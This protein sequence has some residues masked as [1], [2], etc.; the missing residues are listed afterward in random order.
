MTQPTE[1]VI[2][3]SQR[4]DF[5]AD[6]W[7]RAP[8]NR[9]TFQHIGEILPTTPVR[10]N[11]DRISP[12]PTSLQKI[13]TIAFRDAGKPTSV[14]EWLDTSFTDGFIVLSKNEIV[15][16]RYFN[17]MDQATLHL[18]QSVSK[19]V[20]GTA[21]GILVSRGLIDPQ[22]SL[23]DVVPELADTAFRHATLRH[24]LDMTSGVRFDENYIDPYSDA[25]RIDV[26]SGW[27]QPTLPG[28]WPAS[29]LE[30]ILALKTL[31][32][33]HGEKFEYRSIETDIITL[34]M[35]KVTGK[36]LADI[37]S[38]EIWQPIGAEAIASFTIDRTG[39]ALGDGGFNA[40]LRD[41]ARFGL[42]WANHGM[43]SG[44]RLISENWIEE[45]RTGDATLFHQP[46]TDILPMGAYRNQFWLKQAKGQVLLCRGVFGQLIYIDLEK[47]FVAVKLSSWPD[48]TDP[49]RMKTAISAI[50]HVAANF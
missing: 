18:A 50:D 20:T 35:E 27:K 19:S 43:A 36:R 44:K 45:T 22:R 49:A 10:N 28:Q 48:F 9:W 21:C 32:R 40:C 15:Y 11:P 33:S 3:G 42:L 17:G 5:P 23:M 8:W 7:D 41:F 26:A 29:M 4:P 24:V 38:D 34:V 25:G 12:L 14:G 46:Y 6:A 37:I 39:F 31:V 1:S 16:E 47:N 2:S 13:E 30:L